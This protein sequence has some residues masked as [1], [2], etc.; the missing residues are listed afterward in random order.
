[1]YYII[2]TVK[3]YEDFQTPLKHI[4]PENVLASLHDKVEVLDKCYGE[5]RNLLKDLGGYC[6][7]VSGTEDWAELYQTVIDKHYIQEELYEYREVHTDGSC[8]W[9]EELYVTSSD[10]SIVIFYSS[11]HELK[12]GVG[13]L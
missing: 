13:N 8:C 10:Y 9:I 2:G 6:V 11:E 1:M 4:L 12:E 3:Q 7:I 5:T